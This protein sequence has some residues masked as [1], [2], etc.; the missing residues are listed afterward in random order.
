[1]DPADAERIRL[2]TG[3]LQAPRRTTAESAIVTGWIELVRSRALRRKYE[4]ILNSRA[5][6]GTPLGSTAP[7]HAATD[8]PKSRRNAGGRS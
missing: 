5:S 7:R 8:D 6:Y 1:M 2:S 4:E 3:E